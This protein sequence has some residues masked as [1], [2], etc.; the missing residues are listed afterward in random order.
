[1]SEFTRCCA[2]L[3]VGVVSV[4]DRVEQSGARNSFFAAR[5]LVVL[6]DGALWIRNVCEEIF[7][8][9]MVTF[10]INQYHPLEW[11]AVMVWALALDNGERKVLMERIKQLTT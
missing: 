5:E 3:I 7:G 6:C 11:A 8:I 2:R 10:V 9:R 1:M 4:A